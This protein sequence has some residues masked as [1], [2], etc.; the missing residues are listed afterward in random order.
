[1]FETSSP[2][3]ILGPIE[4]GHECFEQTRFL[5]G[6]RDMVPV[7]RATMDRD[8]LHNLQNAIPAGCVEPPG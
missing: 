6:P 3:A 8:C 7:S 1:M 5:Q 4:I 2:C